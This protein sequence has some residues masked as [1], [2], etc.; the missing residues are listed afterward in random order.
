MGRHGFLFLCFFLLCLKTYGFVEITGQ[1]GHDSQAFGKG[2]KVVSRTYSGSLAFYLF[3]LSAIELN[4]SQ[5][6]NTVT[7]DAPRII[8]SNLTVLSQKDRVRTTVY[9]VGIRQALATKNAFIQPSLS[10]GHAKQK[11]KG[12]VEYTFNDRGSLK[13]RTF[14]S[15]D[16]EIDSAFASLGIRLR[17]TSRLMINMSVKTVFP[18]FKVDQAKNNVKY[19]A[20][21]SWYL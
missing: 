11:R 14:Q 18:W 8:D 6:K 20:G 10:F 16:S 12:N 1:Y 2:S 13:A 9:G 4:L 7:D 17:M 19:L 5:N 21:L 15:E 3:G